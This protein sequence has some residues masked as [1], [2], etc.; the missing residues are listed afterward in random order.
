MQ[1]RRAHHIHHDAPQHLLSPA[2]L[3]ASLICLRDGCT[4]QSARCVAATWSAA[5][6]AGVRFCGSFDLRRR[7]TACWPSHL[8]AYSSDGNARRATTCRNGQRS[9]H[10][11]PGASA[12]AQR[13][14]GTC[15]CF[16]RSPY[17]VLSSEY[18]KSRCFAVLPGAYTPSRNGQACCRSSGAKPC[19][20]PAETPTFS[21]H[22]PPV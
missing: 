5:V 18:T 17:A 2:A 16:S 6:A 9:P 21:D 4:M 14:E 7:Q 1:R 13:A 11:A 15:A 10:L 12:G 8:A 22:E 19:P 20:A 3:T